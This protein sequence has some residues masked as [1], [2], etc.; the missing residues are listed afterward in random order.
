[1][2]IAAIQG[3]QN[4]IDL[5]DTPIAYGAVGDTLVVNAAQNGEDFTKSEAFKKVMEAMDLGKQKS[6]D[7]ELVVPPESIDGKSIREVLQ[8]TLGSREPMWCVTRR[9]NSRTTT[10]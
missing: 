2:E 6:G 5:L 10:P 1:M 9:L 7:S 8:S 4:F 3:F